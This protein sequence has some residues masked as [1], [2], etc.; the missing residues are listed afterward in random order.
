MPLHLRAKTVVLQVIEAC[1]ALD[2]GE[3]FRDRVLQPFEHLPARERPLELAHKLLKV[4]LHD[5]IQIDQVPIDIVDDF[6]RSRWAEKVQR[7][8]SREH[9]DVALM[10]RKARNQMVC[11]P[12]LTADPGTIGFAIFGIA[13][14]F[15]VRIRPA[16]R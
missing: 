12:A 8:S 15:S 3:G 5:P 6:D 4:V 9:F 2:I 1:R 11:K 16:Y 14:S 7:R 13:F 10:L